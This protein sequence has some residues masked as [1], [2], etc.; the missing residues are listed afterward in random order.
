MQHEL[1]PSFAT[2]AKSFYS[3][4]VRVWHVMR[5]PTKEEF[6]MV[7]KI[8]AIGILVIGFVGFLIALIVNSIF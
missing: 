7:A 1:K 4:C 6:S 8:S 5:K 2:K 3:Q